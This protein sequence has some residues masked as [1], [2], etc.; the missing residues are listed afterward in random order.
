MFIQDRESL[1]SE[2][3]S[4]LLSQKFWGKV[5]GNQCLPSIP[6]ALKSAKN[7][8]IQY[9]IRFSLKPCFVAVAMEMFSP[10]CR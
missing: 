9:L 8:Q 7:L 5:P 1:N 3:I 6:R 2:S 10:V 4:D